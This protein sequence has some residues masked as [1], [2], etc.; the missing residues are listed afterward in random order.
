MAL[1]NGMPH[2]LLEARR[3]FRVLWPLSMIPLGV[4]LRLYVE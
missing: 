3:V 4:L 1:S 2:A